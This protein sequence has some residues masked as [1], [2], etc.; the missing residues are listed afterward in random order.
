MNPLNLDSR[1]DLGAIGEEARFYG[2]INCHLENPA[3]AFRQPR[4][5]LSVM[6]RLSPST[7]CPAAGEYVSRFCLNHIL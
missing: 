7:A 1:R 4:T 3:R 5:Q 6:R 2:R